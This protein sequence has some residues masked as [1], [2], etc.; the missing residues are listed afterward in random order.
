MKPAKFDYHRPRTLAESV[1]TLG[2]LCEDGEA[3]ILAGGQ[4]L[5]PLMNMRLARPEHLVDLG[6]IPGLRTLSVDEATI[7]IGSMV[8]Q[9]TVESSAE[10][11]AHNGLLCSA[12]RHVA[13]FQIRERGTVGG[14]IV[15]ADP[16]AELPLLAS[17]LDATIEIHGRTQTRAVAAR[18][19]FVSYLTTVLAEDEV[20]STV[21]FPSL[22]PAEGWGFA[23]F[24]RRRGDFAL[25]AAAATVRM[26][27]GR[28]AAARLGFSGVAAVPMLFG[29]IND[30]VVGEL[31]TSALSREVARRAAAAVTPTSDAHA[32]SEDRRD[33]MKH[34][35]MRVLTDST[36]R[37][38]QPTRDS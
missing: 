33:L 6:G 37:A 7:A 24:S 9:R 20:V 18:R 26:T 31:P 22:A 5:I 2:S 1:A 23:E 13:H 38:G 16:S 32:G 4:S 15:H 30:L 28:Y 21:R 29:E 35:T 34:L 12:V 11:A 3:K 19:F 10:V 8:T 36:S 27:A 25:V 14:S 17:L